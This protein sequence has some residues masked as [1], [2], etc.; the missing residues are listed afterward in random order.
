MKVFVI[1]KV[2][3][4]WREEDVQAMVDFLC[5]GLSRHS[6]KVTDDARTV[7]LA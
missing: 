6:E 7:W 2:D 5:D 4:E 3:G 1:E